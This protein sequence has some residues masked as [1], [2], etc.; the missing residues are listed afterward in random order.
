MQVTG[1]WAISLIA[2]VNYLTFVH[3]C[4]K[5]K[6]IFIVCFLAFRNSMSSDLNPQSSFGLTGS[7]KGSIA[8]L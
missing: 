4:F 6:I 5:F 3:K 7:A 1:R 8:L 2:F